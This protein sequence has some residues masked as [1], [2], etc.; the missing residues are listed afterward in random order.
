MV[1]DYVFFTVVALICNYIAAISE[2]T[3]GKHVP[4][5]LT[6]LLLIFSQRLPWQ[7]FSKMTILINVGGIHKE[8]ELKIRKFY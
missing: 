6:Q 7:W 1:S 8:K 2:Q 5:E 3:K 4:G